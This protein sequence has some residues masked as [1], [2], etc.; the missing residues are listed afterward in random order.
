MDLL[1][2]HYSI[3]QISAHR[4]CVYEIFFSKN[5]SCV[6]RLR[7]L[8]VLVAVQ[9]NSSQQNGSAISD[10][11]GKVKSGSAQLGYRVARQSAD[12]MCFRSYA[13][14][15]NESHWSWMTPNDAVCLYSNNARGDV[16]CLKTCVHSHQAESK[17]H[18]S[19]GS[20]RNL[21]LHSGQHIYWSLHEEFKV[22][23]VYELSRTA[24][25][26]WWGT[27]RIIEFLY[28]F[29]QIFESIKHKTWTR[30]NGAVE[31]R[32]CFKFRPS[33]LNKLKSK[34]HDRI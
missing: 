13:S 1:S 11:C 12:A 8:R 34:W 7:W 20:S 19:W 27:N 30:S 14:N 25:H 24:G 22:D 17:V 29:A 26:L 31:F 5:K 2:V 21:H 16:V 18:P 3:I 4:L 10:G 6:H 28:F 33:A 9:V 15:A 23:K 32:K